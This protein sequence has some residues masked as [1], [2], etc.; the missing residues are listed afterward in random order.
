MKKQFEEILP[1]LNTTAIL[2]RSTS[3]LWNSRELNKTI[4]L[5]FKKIQS[6]LKHT[7]RKEI[8]TSSSKNSTKLLSVIRLVSKK[9]LTTIS[10]KKVFKRLKPPYIWAATSKI[11]KREP[12]KQCL[13]LKFKEFFRLL[14]W[15]TLYSNWREILSLFRTYWRTRV[16]LRRSRSWW[17]L[18]YWKWDDFR[19]VWDR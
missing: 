6:S 15:G 10:A 13:I 12:K 16:W 9:I 14:R 2:D 4:K 3:N 19:C 1:W 5:L 11:K 8:A 17:Q 18:E 7:I